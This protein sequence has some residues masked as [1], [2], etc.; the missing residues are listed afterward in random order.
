[1][2]AGVRQRMPTFERCPGRAAMKIRG[3][4]LATLR[5]RRRWIRCFFPLCHFKTLTG[6]CS[7]VELIKQTSRDQGR[8]RCNP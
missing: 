7:V 3:W 2:H 6:T 4:L 1:V 5:R 8:N